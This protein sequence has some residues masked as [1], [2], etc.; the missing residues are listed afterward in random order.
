MVFFPP[1]SYFFPHLTLH[2]TNVAL[3]QWDLVCQYTILSDLTQVYFQC[4]AFIGEIAASMIA[5]RYGRRWVLVVS[6]VMSVA[7]GISLAFVQ[8]YAVFAVLRGLGAIAASVS[9]C[10]YK[11]EFIIGIKFHSSLLL[12][13][14]LQRIIN[15]WHNSAATNTLYIRWYCGCWWL[16]GEAFV[17][18]ID[19]TCFCQYSIR[20]WQCSGK[21]NVA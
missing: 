4:G 2:Y 3:F 17:G 14:N 20:G 15:N 18:K 13:P 1:I 9:R 5:D 19:T 10:L 6:H 12:R 16:L 7:S 11:S 8:S 21:S